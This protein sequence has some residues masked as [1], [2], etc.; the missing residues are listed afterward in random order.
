MPVYYCAGTSGCQRLISVTSVPGGNPMA[1][2]DPE[3]YASVWTLCSCGSFTCDRCLGKQLGHC[4]CGAAARL[5]SEAERIAIAQGGPPI[6]ARVAV[7][8]PPPQPPPPLRQVLE[9]LVAQTDGEL[10]SHQHERARSLAAL[11]ATLMVSQGAS[12]PISDL[13]AFAHV[14][15]QFYRWRFFVEGA[16]YW[17]GLYQVADAAGQ[18]QT[19]DA[20]RIMASAAAFQV[21]SGEVT[22]ASPNAD[23]TAAFVA[24]VFGPTHV[25]TRDVQARLG[26]AA[27]PPAPAEP[28]VIASPAAPATAAATAAFD[29]ATKNAL[30]VTLA[31]LEIAMAD[32]KLKDEEWQAW[33]RTMEKLRLPN[34]YES[35]GAEGLQRMMQQGVLAQLSSELMAR[36]PIDRRGELAE[37]L[38]EFVVADGKIDPG[39]TDALDRITGWLGVAV[40]MPYR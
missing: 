40:R 7:A 23:N 32:G 10:A 36:L 21:L 26:L 15:E 17:K 30:W 37:I 35:I 5:Y 9:D 3:G 31:F 33:R 20:F 25:V 16:Q 28:P 12:A 19:D 38:L 2:G 29:P 34:V 18:G 13:Y 8:P 24:S 27:Q 6:P 39:E 4:K 1:L 14:G 11:A 22:A